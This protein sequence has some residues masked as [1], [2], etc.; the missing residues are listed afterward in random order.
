MTAA[1]QDFMR[2]I[3]SLLLILTALVVNARQVSPEEAQTIAAEFFGS[4]SPKHVSPK[5][6]K[7]VAPKDVTAD[8]QPYYVFNTADNAG[9]VIISGDTRAK[10]ILGYSDK[11]NFNFENMPPQLD[12]LLN[13]YKKQIDSI[14]S[15]VSEDPSWQSTETPA[16]GTEVL[17][18]TANWGQG[19]PYNAQC[20][21][22][23]G[24]QAPTGCVAT[25][26]AIV[27]KY[28]NWP[29]QGRGQIVSNWNG[30]KQIYD[31]NIFYNWDEMPNDFIEGTYDNQQ[32]LSVAK[33]MQMAGLSV[34]TQYGA[35]ESAS[36]AV[37]LPYNIYRFFKYKYMPKYRN[38]NIFNSYFDYT[39]DDWISEIETEIENNRPIIY[40]G[41]NHAFVIDGISSADSN[42]HVNWGWDGLANGWY[43]LDFLSPIDESINYNDHPKFV[44]FITPDK[45]A[46][47]NY[48]ILFMDDGTTAQQPIFDAVNIFD[49]GHLYTGQLKSGHSYASEGG[50]LYISE[51]FKGNIIPVLF[52]KDGN[53]K[54][55]IEYDRSNIIFSEEDLAAIKEYQTHGI[56]VISG[57]CINNFTFNT[58]IN[59]DDYIQL[60]YQREEEDVLHPLLSQNQRHTKF[61]AQHNESDVSELFWKFEGGNLNSD[62]FLSISPNIFNSETN[63]S[64][65][66]KGIETRTHIITTDGL[67]IV[68]MDDEL[69]ISNYLNT[70]SSYVFELAIF[71]NQSYK[72]HKISVELVRFDEMLTRKVFLDNTH[73]LYDY[74]SEKDAM[75]VNVLSIEGEITSE[76][77]N[78]MN[79]SFPLLQKL[80]LQKCVFNNN[81]I[82]SY[83]LCGKGH[84]TRLI[85]PDNIKKISFLAFNNVNG[86]SFELP[87][88]IEQIGG[89]L[90]FNHNLRNVIMHKEE[91]I[92]I[93]TAAFSHHLSSLTLYVPENSVSKYREHP[94]WGQFKEIKGFDPDKELLQDHSVI[95][96]QFPENIIIE[97]NSECRE[98]VSAY[99]SSASPISI[100]KEIG[101][102]TYLFNNQDNIACEISKY[103]ED[104]LLVVNDYEFS[105]KKDYFVLYGAYS[106]GAP[107]Y[108]EAKPVFKKINVHIKD[109]GYTPVI[110]A[111]ESD[112]GAIKIFDIFGREVGHSLDTSDL[113]PGIYIIKQGE[114][115]NK[116]LVR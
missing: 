60:F 88:S 64:I 90:I 76:D 46:D 66:P 109:T 67:P 36:D 78:F 86:S 24:V 56:H 14:P 91:P 104:Y 45:E 2:R 79:R 27:M 16:S 68:R 31:N 77:I 97:R 72:N 12:W 75:Y 70:Q 8:N 37:T 93:N 101:W 54:E 50:V 39:F 108:G 85:L 110:I 92:D 1:P 103:D 40:F 28:H 89:T 55:K 9:F 6:I 100:Y 94:V 63:T 96:N 81:D 105:T 13:E 19:Y 3:I 99:S 58:E 74:I 4:S 98:L 48:E 26:M 116:I 83:F 115:T 25:A 21:I 59:N 69:V 11:G 7:R 22:I 20:P 62:I 113:R 5:G 84:L 23:D 41:G 29:E 38:Y 18:E 49:C 53:I 71:P 112:N 42:V 30:Q 52:D 73:R 57:P 15:T 33:V 44:S 80:D 107:Y 65:I 10:K 102:S 51:P 95:W 34:N 47:E 32:A 87:E 82:P 106:D 35:T 114:K 61:M 43:L 17:L 111:P